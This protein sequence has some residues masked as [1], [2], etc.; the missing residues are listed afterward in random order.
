MMRVKR[1]IFNG[2]RVLTLV[3]LVATCVLWVRSRLP[4]DTSV[5]ESDSHARSLASPVD[6]F[7][8]GG[9]GDSLAQTYDRDFGLEVHKD[10]PIPE[11]PE[12]ELRDIL[13]E[14]ILRHV[15]IRD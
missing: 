5:K 13:G 10:G 8:E 1:I 15:L 7:D 9:K 11:P 12:M 14:S 2:L 6:A 4:H 3:L